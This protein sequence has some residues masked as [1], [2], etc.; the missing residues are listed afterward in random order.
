MKDF[1]KFYLQGK[2]DSNYDIANSTSTSILL[3][4]GGNHSY[5]SLYV[6]KLIWTERANFSWKSLI[7]CFRKMNGC[8]RV[9]S[10]LIHDV[11]KLGYHTGMEGV[12]TSLKLVKY[13]TLKVELGLGGNTTPINPSIIMEIFNNRLQASICT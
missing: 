1:W 4:L 10:I 3:W 2:N 8:P 13:S 9:A 5:G 11:I 12:M 7:S 6:C